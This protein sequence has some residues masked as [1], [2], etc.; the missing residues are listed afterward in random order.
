M[1]AFAFSRIRR[2]RFLPSFIGVKNVGSL[3]RK[4][5]GI[6]LQCNT[7]SAA[8]PGPPIQTPNICIVFDLNREKDGDA[9]VRSP[10]EMDMIFYRPPTLSKDKMSS[11][12]V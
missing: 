5:G 9:V 7:V 11:L 1:L 10:P 8:S 6:D 3:T 4:F 12:S 2:H